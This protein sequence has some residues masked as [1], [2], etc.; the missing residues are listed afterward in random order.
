MKFLNSLI[1]FSF[2]KQ[3]LVINNCFLIF[4]FMSFQS[5]YCVETRSNLYEVTS[6]KY[7]QNTFLSVNTSSRVKCCGYCDQTSGCKSVS[8]KKSS[9]QC[10]L[11]IEPLVTVKVNGQ[12]DTDW[13]VYSKK[14]WMLVFRATSGAGGD[15]Y[16]AWMYGTSVTTDDVTC[17]TTD[18]TSCSKHYRNP[19]IDSWASVGMTQAKF[20]L[21]KNNIEVAYVIFDATGS[22]VTN[23]FSNTRITGSSWSTIS[24]QTF[25]HFSI[26]GHDPGRRFFINPS[27]GGCPGDTGYAVAITSNIFGCSYDIH[28]S[29]PQF[30][31]AYTET[32]GYPE[33]MTG[34]DKAD[35]MAILIK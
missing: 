34:M 28:S 12:T 9:G 7:L 30:L 35:V 17:M 33:T 11:S 23:W 32:Y 10:N 24:S 29:Y 3:S 19:I 2:R 5:V 16:S 20:A 14:E 21:Y 27:Y 8:Y 13:S 26:T 1:S 15:V 25:N 6:D 31:Y 4:L 18:V 22:D